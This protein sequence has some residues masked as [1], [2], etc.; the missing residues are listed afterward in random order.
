VSVRPFP[1]PAPASAPSPS[2]TPRSQQPGL[3]VHSSVA[4]AELVHVARQAAASDAKVLVTGESGVGKDL[5][6]RFIHAHSSRAT[7]PFVAVNCAGFTETL[8]E[9]ELFGHVKG[10]FTGAYRDKIGQLQLAHGGTLFLDELGE[11]SLRMQA[12]LLRFMENG[13]IQPVGAD[14]V[15]T[16][17]DVR[18][19][20]ATNRNLDERVASGEFR[21]DLLFR[22]RVIHLHVPPLRERPEDVQALLEH[23]VKRSGRSIR[24]SDASMSLMRAY[25]WPGNVREL[26]NVIEQTLALAPRDVIEPADLPRSVRE[27]SVRLLPRRERRRQV[28]DDMFQA[29]TEGQCSFWDDVYQLFAHRDITRHDIRELVKKGLAQ[30]RGNYRAVLRL[31]GLPPEDYKKFLNFLAAHECSVDFRPF[32]TSAWEEAAAPAMNRISLRRRVA[33]PAQLD[34]APSAPAPP[35]LPGDSRDHDR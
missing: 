17:L 3:L 10:S 11:M 7:G 26:Q 27:S 31:F 18:V 16:G 35:A 13:E 12:L 30:T 4:M 15:R 22:L 28:A 6:A 24:F 23:F 8:L 25:R 20:G 5:I 1:T 21:E 34:M 19:V 29:L 9:S 14:R 33:P 32:R 2:S